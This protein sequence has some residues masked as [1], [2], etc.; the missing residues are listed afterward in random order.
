M[1]L[2][3]VHRKKLK[4]SIPCVFFSVIGLKLSGKNYETIN[5][6]FI[7][8]AQSEGVSVAGC[9]HCQPQSFPLHFHS[10]CL[11]HFSINLHSLTPF[12][13]P[14]S[15]F[16]Q[17]TNKM[18]PNSLLLTYMLSFLFLFL[19]L[20]FRLPLLLAAVFQPRILSFTVPCR[21]LAAM[22]LYVSD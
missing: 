21:V 7:R 18:V 4:K 8:V 11:S 2:I 1:A 12:I 13:E 10:F 14:G 17:R 3:Y 19:R 16:L 15:C 9:Q 6:V 22:R 5:W 20:S